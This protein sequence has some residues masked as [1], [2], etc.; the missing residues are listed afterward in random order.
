M[1]HKNGQDEGMAKTAFKINR[2]KCWRRGEVE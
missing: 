1:D 2:Q